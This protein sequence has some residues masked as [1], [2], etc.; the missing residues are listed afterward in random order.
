MESLRRAE[1]D[2]NARLNHHDIA[3]LDDWYD[4]IGMPPTAGSADRG[5]HSDKLLRVEFTSILTD[6]GRPCL[7]FTYNYTRPLYEGLFR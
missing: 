1:N 3:S 2:I 6:D 4:I 5:W 7:A